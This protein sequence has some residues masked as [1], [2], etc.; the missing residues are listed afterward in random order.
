[1]ASK[2]VMVILAKVVKERGYNY[3]F[4]NAYLGLR[5]SDWLGKEKQREAV[6][7]GKVSTKTP[8]DYVSEQREKMR[9]AVL[10]RPA[11]SAEAPPAEAAQ[12][13]H[14]AAD[15]SSSD[16]AESKSNDSEDGR[17]FSPVTA[18]TPVKFTCTV[19]GE[20][21]GTLHV[22]TDAEVL[23]TPLKDYNKSTEG[24]MDWDDDMKVQ[25][26][27]SYVLV[28]TDPL[29]RKTSAKSKAAFMV[30]F[31]KEKS[32]KDPLLMERGIKVG[33]D[34]FKLKSLAAVDTLAQ[35]MA[36]RGLTGQ[37]S[38]AGLAELVHQGVSHILNPTIDDVRAEVDGI[39]ALAKSLC[40]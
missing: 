1:M 14:P 36:F 33:E 7:Y 34:K 40:Q 15:A 3:C 16:S 39:V 21:I 8:R 13:P 28:A 22:P 19:D 25:L 31:K 27:K 11:P 5:V 24:R 6:V 2:R 10:A 18:R 35:F 17:E 38:G 30:N 9:A 26:L 20:V 37:P 32:G 29:A 12:T 4:G 23:V